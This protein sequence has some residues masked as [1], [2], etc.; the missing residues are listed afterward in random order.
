M[1][2]GGM[3][4][5]EPDEQEQLALEVVRRIGKSFWDNLDGI[6]GKT[7]EEIEAELGMTS[8]EAS[9][10]LTRRLRPH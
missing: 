3:T 10:I 1:K 5:S 8:K 2:T 9:E 6:D 7:F 4:I